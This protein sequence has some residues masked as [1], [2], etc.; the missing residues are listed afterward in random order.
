MD[1]PI[2]KAGGGRYVWGVWPLHMCVVSQARLLFFCWAPTNVWGNML[3]RTGHSVDNLP[4][5]IAFSDVLDDTMW[6]FF[7]IVEINKDFVP[8]KNMYMMNKT[9]ATTEGG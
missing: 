6:G 2:G 5:P 4:L 3:G 9:S 8:V 7:A 1:R